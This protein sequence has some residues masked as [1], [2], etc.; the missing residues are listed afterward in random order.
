[1]KKHVLLFTLI[2][3]MGITQVGWGQIFTQDFNYST[4]ISDYYNASPTT[5]QFRTLSTTNSSNST[6]SVSTNA[7]VMT[8]INANT[9]TAYA[10]RNIDF[11]SIP[12]GLK[13]QFTFSV[14]GA[15]A[16]LNALYVVV[17]ANVANTG[18]SPTVANI[19]GRFTL[20]TTANSGE[21]LIR[22][23]TNNTTGLT[24]Y[25]GTQTITWVLNNTSSSQTYTA[26][27]NSTESIAVDKADIWVGTTKE[28]DDIVVENAGQ[29]LARFKF[30]TGSSWATGAVFTIDDIV[31]NNETAL[32]VELTSFSASI[33]NKTVNLTWQ[34]ATEVNN[35]GFEV[36]RGNR[37][38]GI[39]NRQQAI[40]SSDWEKVGFV[41]GAGNSNSPKEYSF[42]D[43][44]AASGKYLYRL[45]QLDND[46]QYSYSKEV[47]VDL[48]TPTAFALEQN[49]PNPFNPTTSIQYSVVRSQN[50]TIKVFNVLGKEVAVLVNEKQ[51]PGTYTV[52]FSTANLASGTYIYRMQAGEFVQTKKM[53]VLK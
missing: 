16:A 42:T 41:N 18:G 9:T 53:I 27:N 23:M 37:Q 28:F 1:M 45:K 29:T 32:P 20:N 11:T 5:N 3:F 15:G 30:Y 22:D 7:I 43:K 38:E 4:T 26:P 13:L 34:T 52:E 14:T 2:L 51:E 12:T 39:G 35:Y 36:E 49:Y 47:E 31:I 50:V 48:G 25:T 10:E 40:G 46:G 44:S 21:F 6:L 33:Q 19:Y 8:R 24:T 17:G